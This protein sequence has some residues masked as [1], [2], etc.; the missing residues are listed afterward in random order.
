MNK[1]AV[2]SAHSGILYSRQDEHATAAL[3]RGMTTGNI[4]WD[5]NAKRLY[6]TENPLLKLKD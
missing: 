5:T 6:T 4:I 2:L 1:C 3:I